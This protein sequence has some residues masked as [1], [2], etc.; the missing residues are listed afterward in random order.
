MPCQL[1]FSSKT[2][3]KQLK[4]AETTITDFKKVENVYDRKYQ[5]VYD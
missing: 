1:C 4:V 2:R 3:A 5:Q